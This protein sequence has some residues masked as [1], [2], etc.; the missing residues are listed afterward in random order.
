[1]AEARALIAQADADSMTTREVNAESVM[2]LS[3]RLLDFIS[4]LLPNRALLVLS[5]GRM[6]IDI[7]TA[8]RPSTKRMSKG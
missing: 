1:M 8:S 6:A 3:W 7:L 5:I 4:L 2:A